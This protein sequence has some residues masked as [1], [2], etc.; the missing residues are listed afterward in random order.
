MEDQ[1]RWDAAEWTAVSKCVRLAL[2]GM[3]PECLETEEYPEG[4]RYP[5]KC[6]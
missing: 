5:S 6:S 3:S 2:P 1:S 4:P